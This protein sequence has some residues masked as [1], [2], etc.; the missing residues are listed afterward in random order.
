MNPQE[1][2]ERVLKMVQDSLD[3]PKEGTVAPL[4]DYGRDQALI[5]ELV[6]AAGEARNFIA[7]WKDVLLSNMTSDSWT[8]MAD[9]LDDALAK[10]D[11]AKET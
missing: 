6:D 7:T 3:K 11:K 8:E 9:Q 2:Q 5:T 1:Y 4:T 10:A